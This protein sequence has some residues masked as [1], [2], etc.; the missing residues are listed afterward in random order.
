MNDEIA[1]LRTKAMRDVFIEALGHRMK[2]DEDIFF[3]ARTSVRPLSTGYEK[4]V[5]ADS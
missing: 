4:N 2:E 1:G 5:P 3:Y